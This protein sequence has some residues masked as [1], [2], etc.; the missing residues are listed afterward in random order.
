MDETNSEQYQS[1]DDDPGAD[2]DFDLD[3][4]DFED[5]NSDLMRILAIAGGA[6]ALVGGLMILRGRRRQT[7]AEQLVAAAGSTASHQRLMRGPGA[8]AA[9]P[10]GTKPRS[11]RAEPGGLA[12]IRADRS[13]C[14]RSLT[15]RPASASVMAA[16][17]QSRSVRSFMRGLRS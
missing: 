12:M 4:E 2:L 14:V 17:S 16:S 1:L 13:A 3:D 6:A 10:A 7:P 5:E 15:S 11:R 8:R 9:G